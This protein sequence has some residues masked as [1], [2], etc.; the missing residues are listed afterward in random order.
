MPRPIL[1]AVFL[2][3]LAALPASAW[4]GGRTDF[5]GDPLPDGAVARLGTLRFRLPDEAVATALAADGNVVAVSVRDSHVLVLD[6]AGKELCRVAAAEPA[7]ALAL[8]PDGGVL[9]CDAGN[10]VRLVDTTTGKELRA[11]GT[12]GPPQGLAFSADGKRLAAVSG[13]GGPGEKHCALVWDVVGGKEVARF[14]LLARDRGQAALSADGTVLATWSVTQSSVDPAVQVWDVAGGKE[15]RRIGEKEALPAAGGVALA[16]DG[17]TLAVTSLLIVRVWDVASGKETRLPARLGV[18]PVLAF[19]RDGGVLAACT[20]HGLVLRWELP[21]GKRLGEQAGPACMAAALTFRADGKPVALG[22][23]G[24]SL[25]LWEGLSGKR[26]SP[27]REHRSPVEAIAFSPDGKDLS[28]ADWDGVVCTW[29]VATGKV[30]RRR[31]GPDQ[32]PVPEDHAFG[33]RHLAP[34]SGRVAAAA[35][36][37][38]ARLWD[39]DGK[40]VCDLEAPDAH[41]T[42][43]PGRGLCFTADGRRLA[44]VCGDGVCVWDAADGSE[45]GRVRG[46]GRQVVVVALSPDGR[47]LAVATYVRGRKTPEGQVLVL[48]LPAGKEVWRLDVGERQVRDLAFSPDG[49]LLALGC[50]QRELRLYESGTGKE[51]FSL[52]PALESGWVGYRPTFSP[53]G[54]LLA[55][56]TGDS[57]TEGRVQL[58]ETASGTLRREFRTGA[59]GATSL[60]FS[61]DG[62]TLASGGDGTVLLWDAVGQASGQRKAPTAAELEALW[63]GLLTHDAQDAFPTLLRLAAAPP[64]AVPWLR[65]HVRPEEAPDAAEVARLIAALDGDEFAARERA[66]RTLEQTGAGARAAVARALEGKPSAEATRRLKAILER[67]DATRPSPELLRSLRAVEVLERVGTPEARRVLEELAAGRADAL[68]TREAKAALARLGHARPE[69]VP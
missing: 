7:S 23:G 8:S 2:A 14:S 48:G 39:F 47:S 36:S 65:R 5:Y 60:A 10:A 4:P 53:D 21:S 17:K 63:E 11:L 25:V 12:P 9:A 27:E 35:D 44:T 29:D 67:L 55:T 33:P 66:Q 40:T 41:D 22:T 20:I 3:L 42:D 19:S 62:K 51:V 68:L 56:S 49:R 15:I 59:N 18:G 43:V 58:W 1:L 24:P 6:A 26:L 32:L 50:R 38:F 28:S 37:L 34:A 31:F 52:A 57:E 30:R 46:L 64:E 61:P 45:V 16:P 54:R 69:E 13:P